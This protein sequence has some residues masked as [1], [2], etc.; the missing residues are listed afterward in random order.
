VR[1]YQRRLLRH[2]PVVREQ[3][4]LF[5]RQAANLTNHRSFSGILEGPPQAC[6]SSV[7]QRRGV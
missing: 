1:G 4:R 2:P 7:N 6:H 5:L 3:R